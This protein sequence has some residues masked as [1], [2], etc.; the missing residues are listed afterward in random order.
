MSKDRY[1]IPVEPKAGKVGTLAVFCFGVF[2][3][4]MVFAAAYMWTD[5]DTQLAGAIGM[6]SIAIPMTVGY[7]VS[8]IRHQRAGAFWFVITAAVLAGAVGA[9]AFNEREAFEA[10]M[11]LMNP[12]AASGYQVDSSN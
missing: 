12:D 7:F 8:E 11:D 4:L 3:I 1:D 5:A 10:R 2:S 9:W 6:A